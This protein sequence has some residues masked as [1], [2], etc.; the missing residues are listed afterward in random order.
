METIQ[1]TKANAEAALNASDKTTKKVLEALFGDQ[2][3]PK[4]IIERVKTFEDAC[5][6]CPPSVN[7]QTLFDYNGVDEEMIFN[8]DI[9]KRNYFAKVL[10]ES[11]V[12]DYNNNSQKR[13]YVWFKWNGSGFVFSNAYYDFTH[14][15]AGCGSRFDFPTKEIAE[16]FATHEVELHNAVLSHN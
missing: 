13:W 15:Y 1:I 9:A 2:L 14:S 11:F 16:H 12:A 3:K 10:R 8:R 6:E 5:S 7:L 4:S